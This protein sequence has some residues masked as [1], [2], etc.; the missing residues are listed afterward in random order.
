MYTLR[1]FRAKTK[2][3]F[4]KARDGSVEIKR[5]KEIYI[6]MFSSLEGKYPNRPKD[7]A[8]TLLPEREVDLCEHFAARGLCKK[9]KCKYSMFNP[10]NK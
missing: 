1:E 3:A 2:E 7:Q 10:K 5:G 9:S 8:I 6:L 4:D